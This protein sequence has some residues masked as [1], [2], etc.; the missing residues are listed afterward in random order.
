[1][2]TL[3]T[4]FGSEVRFLNDSIETACGTKFNLKNKKIIK[5]VLKF[6]GIPHFG[7]RVRAYYINRLLDSQKKKQSLLDAGCGI[8]LN[9]FLIAKKG[10]KVSGVDMDNK[11][12]MLAKKI[13][14]KI[15]YSNVDFYQMDITNLK[16][17]NQSFDSAICIETLEHIKE[18]DKALKE[19]SRVLKKEGVFILSVPGVGLISKIN[20]E[21][22]HHVREGYSFKQIKNKLENNGFKIDKVIKIEHT[23]LG[24]ALRLL[25]DEIHK[26]SLLITTLLFPIF[27]PLAILDGF[28]PEI[29][30]PNNWLLIARK[31]SSS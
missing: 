10:F 31:E 5:N 1:M 25:N 22:K 13:L 14:S 26:R 2:L 30:T 16:F 12:I 8:G 27:F 9:T 23:P 29:I 6:T 18:D 17:K 21:N 24:F 3:F 7:A 28:L 19:I 20:K 11:K 15:D 4:P